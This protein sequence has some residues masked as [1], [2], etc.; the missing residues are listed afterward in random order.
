MPAKVIETSIV[1]ILKTKKPELLKEYRTISLCNVIYKIVSK[2]LVNRLRPLLEEVISPTQSAF[3]PCRMITDNALIAFECLHVIRSG[4]SRNKSFGV[5]K[6]DLTKAYDHVD[7]TYLEGVLW[8]LGF[9]SRWMQWVMECV[10]TVKYLVRFNNVLLD[11]FQPM[12]GLRQGGLLSP[13]IFLFVAYGLLK[14]L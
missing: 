8:R 12:C 13:Y 2:C 4:N 3:I 7:W 11:S 5:F 14:F 1:L 6:L 10:I 9:Q